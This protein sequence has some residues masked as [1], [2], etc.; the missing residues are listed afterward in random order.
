MGVILGMLLTVHCMFFVAAMLNLWIL[1]FKSISSFLYIRFGYYTALTNC[2]M[3]QLY[4]HL[5]NLF[6]VLHG[7]CSSYYSSTSLG[8]QYSYYVLQLTILPH[9][10]GKLQEIS[11][12]H[13]EVLK[14]VADAERSLDSIQQR[15]DDL[16]KQTNWAQPA[17]L[18]QHMLVAE[19]VQ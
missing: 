13:L 6:I 10:W 4:L 7:I 2:L 9:R 14:A 16:V 12:K 11:D 15:K 8:S 17:V 19:V 3:K 1:L 5:W 18:Q